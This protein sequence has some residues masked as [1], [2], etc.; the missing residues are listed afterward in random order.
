[1]TRDDLGDL[2]ALYKDLHAHPEL[3]FSEHRT[4]GIAAERLEV[5]GTPIHVDLSP[6][7]AQIQPV[8]R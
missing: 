2:E 1:M 7:F 3:P 4:A 6:L 5:P 8:A